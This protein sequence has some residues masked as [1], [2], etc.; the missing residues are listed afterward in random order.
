MDQE[1]WIPTDE[2]MMTK[3]PGI[4]AAGDVRAKDLRQITTAVGEGS[5]AGQEAYNY[6]QNQGQL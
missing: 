4:F 1:G 2:H 3:I 6:L 5:T